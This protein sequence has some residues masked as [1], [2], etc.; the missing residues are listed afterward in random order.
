M[1]R[2]KR[3]QTGAIII[4]ETERET[5]V[6]T[7]V[8]PESESTPAAFHKAGEHHLEDMP[9]YIQMCKIQKVNQLLYTK[10]GSLTLTI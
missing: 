8:Q 3:R 5:P 7:T 10:Q 2:Q 6:M 1:R 9:L 4:L